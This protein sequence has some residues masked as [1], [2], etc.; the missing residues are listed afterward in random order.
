M[1][2]TPVL[3]YSARTNAALVTV[4]VCL[5]GSMILSLA[6]LFPS[7]STN[8]AFTDMVGALPPELRDAL[9]VVS[10][11]TEYLGFL[12]ANYYNSLHIIFLM[13]FVVL[14][15]HRLVSLPIDTTSLSY[16]LSGCTS[17]VS[18][19]ITQVLIFGAALLG[20][21]IGSILFAV[22]GHLAFAEGA[23]DWSGII[24]LNV[25][26]LAIFALLGAVAFLIRMVTRTGT[27]ALAWTSSIVV[28]LYFINV[29]R[30]LAPDLTWLRYITVFSLFDMEN[31]LGDPGAFALIVVV[32]LAASAAIAA[33]SVLLFRRKDLYL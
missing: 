27:E 7:L 1:I 2:S 16:F 24:V 12:S 8:S 15:P 30:G 21:T 11:Q 18:Y 19:L 29:A 4:F 20:V 3:K 25:T 26:L 23:V 9:G 13:A 31:L 22:I 5:V 10:D 14:M 28:A 6:W 33:G 32:L 17:R